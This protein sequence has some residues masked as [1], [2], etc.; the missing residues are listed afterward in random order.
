MAARSACNVGSPFWM[1][2][3]IAATC[4]SLRPSAV[5]SPFPGP[6]RCANA[7]TERVNIV[8]VTPIILFITLL[9]FKPRTAQDRH[10]AH[11][12]GVKRCKRAKDQYM[13]ILVCD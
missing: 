4:A 3:L 8:T 12:K 1:V 13:Q 5:F 6:P 11:Q 10:L 7:T 2:V 9:L